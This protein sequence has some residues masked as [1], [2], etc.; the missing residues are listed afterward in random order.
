MATPISPAEPSTA[1]ELNNPNSLTNLIKNTEEQKK[2]ALSDTKYDTKGSLYD[3]FQDFPTGQ[4]AL[5]IGL[6]F[7]L[8]A[9]FL[10]ILG[11]LLPKSRKR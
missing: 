4:R 3:G 8:A 6:S 11:G 1:S 7:A 2:Q 5:S 9:G 10:L